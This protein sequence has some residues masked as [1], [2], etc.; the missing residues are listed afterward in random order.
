MSWVVQ[1]PFPS[2]NSWLS[3]EP[4]HVDAAQMV[5]AVTS[6]HV[7][8]ALHAPVVPHAPPTAQRSP[9]SVPILASPQE[10]L[11]EPFCFVLAL[12]AWQAPLQALSQ[13]T[14]FTQNPVSHSVGSVQVSPLWSKRN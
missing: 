2:H 12:H 3:V 6:A 1:A 5:P 4:V 13:H 8:T 10:P 11:T 14:P 7:P 9:G